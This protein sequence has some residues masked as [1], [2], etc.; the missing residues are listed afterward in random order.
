LSREDDLKRNLNTK[1]PNQD[2]SNNQRIAAFVVGSLLLGGAASYS[3][4][5]G[6]RLYGVVALAIL[7]MLLVSGLTLLLRGGAEESTVRGDAESTVRGD[8]ESTVR[9]DAESTV[10]SSG[11]G[12]LWWGSSAVFLAIGSFVAVLDDRYFLAGAGAAGALIA[13]G[14]AYADIRRGVT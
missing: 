4:L 10:R 13:G 1:S 5:Y 7:G 2:W 8:A 14:A 3:L 11:L 12:A 9:G 6:D